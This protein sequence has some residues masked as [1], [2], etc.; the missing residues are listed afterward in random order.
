M[1]DLYKLTCTVLVLEILN[2]LVPDTFVQ[3]E[4][5]TSSV[6]FRPLITGTLHTAAQ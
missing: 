6:H 3:V 4:T 2:T 5:L 1:T